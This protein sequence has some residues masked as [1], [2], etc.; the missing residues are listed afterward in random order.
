M[1]KLSTI[2]IAIAFFAG[3]FPVPDARAFYVEP[4]GP[5]VPG[6]T[7]KI[8]VLGAP[9]DTVK[10]GLSFADCQIA[11]PFPFNVTLPLCLDPLFEVTLFGGL[12]SP[13]KVFMLNPY[14]RPQEESWPAIW[15]PPGQEFIGIPLNLAMLSL[16]PFSVVGAYAVGGPP[17]MM[18]EEPVTQHG[19]ER[20]PEV[21]C[22]ADR[23]ITDPVVSL[24]YRPLGITWRSQLN[25][26]LGWGARMCLPASGGMILEYRAAQ[27]N[28][29]FLLRPPFLSG[30]RLI[31]HAIAAI[32]ALGRHTQYSLLW[33]LIGGGSNPLKFLYGF[34]DYLRNSFPRTQPVPYAV[35]LKDSSQ[36]W[37][38][39]LIEN[40]RGIPYRIE[41]GILPDM[42]YLSN[43][44]NS[45]RTPVLLFTS[46]AGQWPDKHAVVLEDFNPNPLPNGRYAVRIADPGRG[47]RVF[48]AEM[49]FNA[50][51]LARD[52]YYERN[53]VE[54]TIYGSLAMKRR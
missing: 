42:L 46:V 15:M 43:T 21:L 18:I 41:Y 27:D 39:S 53:R 12:I 34:M 16:P 20:G 33:P 49:S 31:P 10:I 47:N 35:E 7:T 32:D 48:P 45:D 28:N 24:P 25:S 5:F 38:P 26:M 11:L 19:A 29:P 23:Q 9:Y 36:E 2:V 17:R 30:T 1:K 44:L 54:Y 22:A 4:L 52:I 13:G 51:N 3:A 14:G 6:Q 8:A 50:A 37:S 40:Y